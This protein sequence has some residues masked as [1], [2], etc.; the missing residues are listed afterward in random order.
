MIH[1]NFISHNVKGLGDKRKR[2]RQFKYL[3][4]QVRNN[5]IIFFQETHSCN[6]TQKKWVQ[7]FGKK[8]TIIFSHGKS[9]AR[10]VAIGFCGN[11]DYTLVKTETDSEGRFVIIEAKMKND[12]YVFINFYNENDEANQ[13]KLFEKLESSL[14]KFDDLNQKKLV[15]SGDFNLFFDSQLEAEGGKPTLKK[16]SISKIIKI[17]ETHDLIDI[18]RVRNRHSKKFT[19]TQR[20]A[21]GFLQRRLDFIFISNSLQYL[22]KD[23]EIGT[24]FASDHS[25][26]KMSLLEPSASRRGPGFWK[27]NKSLLEDPIFIE[28]AR[29]FLQVIID[30]QNL[31]REKQAN[32]EYLKYEFR[33]FAMKYSKAKALERRK[34]KADLEDRLKVLE[35]SPNFHN[36]DEYLLKKGQLEDLYAKQVEGARVRS[37]CKDYELGE[38]STK[39]FLNLEKHR[40]N[41]SSITRLISDDRDVTS[42]KDINNELHKFYKNLYSNR[43][44]TPSVDTTNKLNTIELKNLS[45]NEKLSCE[46]P[47]SER[48]LFDALNEMNEDTSPG[49]DGLTVEFYKFFW[50]DIKNS[51]FASIIEGKIKGKL[52]T[53]QRQA[54]IKL[55]EK[56]D[57]DKKKSGRLGIGSALKD[58]GSYAISKA[59][60]TGGN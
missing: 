8:D 17:K 12:V 3:Q 58:L 43:S 28:K 57:K 21:S 56:K 5:G 48:E 14:A 53:S 22:V 6:T 7:E 31:S 19:F 37:K 46:T 49:N 23:V 60:A 54:I 33:K 40:A 11:L 39:Y 20:H 47:I 36:N 1:F 38:K 24:A 34:N 44:T 50:N 16:N 27:F 51:L 4:D 35:E 30:A 9:N 10:G 59:Q 32:W 45:D 52:S 13:L 15:L 2:K 25:P 55:I 41:M 29:T 26:V 18:W 42:Q